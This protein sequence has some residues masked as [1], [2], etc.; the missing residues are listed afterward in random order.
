MPRADL[1]DITLDY[2][3]FGDPSHETVLLIHGLGAARVRWPRELFDALVDRGFHVVAFDNRDSGRSTVLRDHPLERGLPG[4]M[5][6]GERVEPPYTLRDLADDAVGLLD[7]LGIDQAHVVGASMGGMIAQHLA[8]AHP[9]RVT[10]LTSVMSSTGARTVGQA[11]P[12]ALAVLMTPPPVDDPDR[13]VEASVRAQRTI[14]SPIHWDE[15]RAR[16][17]ARRSFEHGVHPDGTLRQFVAILHDRDRTPRLADIDRPTL[18]IHGAL[19]PLID[20][21]GGHATAEAIA[22]ASL[23]ILEE[24]AHDVPLPLVPRIADA[25]ADHA[26]S[27]TIPDRV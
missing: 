24:M 25:I 8:L 17:Y 19:D 18:V 15:E 6:Q 11:T 20:V 23:V 10:T 16:E 12:E 7:H 27:A 1:G 3:T 21:S 9:G 14:S 22:G 13:F 5:L 26:R 2:D 4:R